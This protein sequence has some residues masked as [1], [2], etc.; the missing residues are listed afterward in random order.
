[1]LADAESAHGAQFR[2]QLA[3]R[4]STRKAFVQTDHDSALRRS[5]LPKSHGNARKY[6]PGE[7]VMVWRQGRGAYADQWTG[8]MKVVVPLEF[9][10][11]VDNNGRQLY[12]AA[13][14]HVRPVSA[15]EAK[16]IVVPNVP[17]NDPDITLSD[18][19]S[20]KQQRNPT[21]LDPD[22]INDTDLR[23]EMQP[24]AKQEHREVNPLKVAAMLTHPHATASSHEHQ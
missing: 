20:S 10:D 23:S 4:E 11:G 22:A 18:S 24:D 14:E 8:P 1:M 13:P 16:E 21:A 7:R 9:S 12:R 15:M 19:P 6:Q 3:R 2:L 17:L 5:I